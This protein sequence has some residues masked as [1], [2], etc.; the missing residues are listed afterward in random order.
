MY[1][2][3]NQTKQGKQFH[4]DNIP[5]NT[6]RLIY[7]FKA[8]ARNYRTNFIPIIDTDRSGPYTNSS[9]QSQWLPTDLEVQGLASIRSLITSLMVGRADGSLVVQRAAIFNTFIILSLIRWDT[10]TLWSR[11]L[12]SVFWSF[13]QF[14]TQLTMSFPSPYCSSM[15][16]RVVSSSRST[17]P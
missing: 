12:I 14:Q 7:M 10:T 4:W 17:T 13:R 3:R 9:V 1:K 16:A 5:I 2:Q 11:I 6:D 8:V 15:G